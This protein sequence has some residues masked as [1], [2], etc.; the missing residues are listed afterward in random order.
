M[1]VIPQ[2]FETA[3]V[4]ADTPTFADIIDALEKD[5]G[6][7]RS[8]RRD[9]RSGLRRVA[10]VLGKDPAAV[11]ASPRWLRPRIAAVAPAAHGLSSKSWSNAQSNVRAS[12]AHM[13]IVRD[14]INKL[15]QLSPEWKSLWVQLLDTGDRG[16]TAT[17]HRLVYFL[18]GLGISPA[19]TTDEHLEAFREALSLSQV[20]R[21]PE[22]AYSN[23]IS[24]WNRA[25]LKVANWPGCSLT[26]PSRSKWI[27]LP[28]ASYPESFREDLEEFC[29]KL[30]QPDPFDND[31][32]HRAMRPS[33]IAQYRRVIERFAAVLVRAGM[34]CGEITS[35]TVL[36]TPNNLERGLRQ[37]LS[38]HG[39]EI[40]QTLGDTARIF[41]TVAARHCTFD[42]QDNARLDNIVHRVTQKKTHGMTSKNRDRLRPL[43]DPETR[44]RLLL[45][46]DRL[47]EKAGSDT[48][49][50]SCLLR[51]QAIAIAIL[52]VAP[53]RAGNLVSIDLDRHLQRPGDGTLFLVFEPGEV[54]NRQRVEFELP[55]YLADMIKLHLGLRSP[56]LCPATTTWL[57]PKRNGS[58]NMPADHLAKSVKKRIRRELGL[59]VNLHLFRH[60][61]AHIMLEAHPGNYEGARRLLGHSRLSTTLNA[62]TG[63]ETATA[64]RLFGD[65]ISGERAV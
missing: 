65:I 33:S 11:P 43:L 62:Y 47:F 27:K 4:P 13:G 55:Q 40:R 45:L 57:F 30:A 48:R 29:V 14:R 32:F 46:P 31:D 52:N 39:G 28:L 18:D 9:L 21:D 23:A 25:P 26:R 20:R 16:L 35:L 58:G 12:L 63:F 61:A 51:E 22:V 42:A 54:K 34:Q 5:T 53:I 10:H 44:R 64:S 15:E 6:L 56:A 7:T 38:D 50:Q 8:R 17:L 2:N 1:S 3:F 49:R 24:A 19:E 37:M 41:R 59:T 60:Q 36:A